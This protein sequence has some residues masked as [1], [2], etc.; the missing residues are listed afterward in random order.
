MTRMRQH[1]RDK[2]DCQEHH[3]PTAMHSMPPDYICGRLTFEMAV[4]CYSNK[5]MCSN[6]VALETVGLMA[7]MRQQNNLGTKVG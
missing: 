2:V 4:P 1:E 7:T 6:M 3:F 5:A